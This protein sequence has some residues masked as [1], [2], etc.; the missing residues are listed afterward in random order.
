MKHENTSRSHDAIALTVIT[1]LTLVIAVGCGGGGGGSTADAGAKAGKAIFDRVCA[2]CHGKDANGLPKLG[3]GLGE[4][5]RN[6]KDSVKPEDKKAA[7]SD[8]AGAAK[9]AND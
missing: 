8:D 1:L 3:K 7:T 6:F 5:I 9:E 4:G 2:T